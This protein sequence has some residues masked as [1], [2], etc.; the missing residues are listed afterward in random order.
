MIPATGA[1]RELA[2]SIAL[3]ALLA[4]AYGAVV[5]AGHSLVRVRV[6]LGFLFGGAAILAMLDRIPIEEGI[7]VDLRQ[8]PVALAGG[9]LGWQGA[10]VATALPFA[11]RIGTGGAGMPAG[12]ASILISGFAG[13]LWHHRTRGAPRRG[14]LAMLGLALLSSTYPAAW[15]L[16]PAPIVRDL[17]AVTL[18]LMLPLHVLG[19][20]VVGSL[21]ERERALHAREQLLRRDADQDALTGLLNRRGFERAIA[22]L[23]LHGAGALLLLDLDHFKRINDLHGHPAGDAVLRATG[24]R[25]RAVLGRADLL[26][27]LGGEEFAVFLPDRTAAEAQDMA[28]RLL[29][30]VR[31]V[32]FALPGGGHVRV[33]TSVGGTLGRPASL[34]LLITQA[35]AALYA[36]KRAGRDRCRFA[37]GPLDLTDGPAFVPT[38]ADCSLRDACC[39][40]SDR[41]PGAPC[42]PLER[43]AA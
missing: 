31:A 2:G 23:P 43:P 16:L 1:V 13:L 15:V 32:P 14:P 8:L 35:D 33:T 41:P 11:V 28:R 18:P 37:T 22:R 38:C 24:R 17:L 7:F 36:A 6:L 40:G 30:A 20:L 39:G 3:M 10:A 42:W 21:I 25:L 29:M 26:A 12:A 34:D 4:V 19:V 27:R 5:R 9:F